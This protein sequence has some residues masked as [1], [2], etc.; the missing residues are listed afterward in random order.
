MLATAAAAGLLLGA[1]GGG[2]DDTTESQGRVVTTSGGTTT[3]TASTT[4]E[5][6]NN[7]AGGGSLAGA[8]GTEECQKAALTMGQA[9][10]SVGA[11]TGAT[12][13][14]DEAGKML[15]EAADAAPSE[16]KADVATLADGFA[17]I[18]DRIGGV[19]Y[20]PQSGQAPPK[21]YMSAFEVFNDTKYQKASEN[22]TKWFGSN[23]GLE[24]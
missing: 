19:T 15:R 16:I 4:P 10:A 11:G 17:E 3:T 22:L 21:E 12:G 9:M 20:D 6:T 18:Y 1:C 5:G 7:N 8:F 13:T 24:N 2:G 14:F 23:C